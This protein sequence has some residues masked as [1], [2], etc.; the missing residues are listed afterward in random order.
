[1]ALHFWQLGL[2]VVVGGDQ[3]EFISSSFIQHALR[4]QLS[5]RCRI[6]PRQSPCRLWRGEGDTRV[7]DHATRVPF[8]VSGAVKGTLDAE[9]A[10][11]CT[12][13][14]DGDGA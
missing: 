2:Q 12:V 1:M 11:A 10:D 5:T 8:T 7:P 9:M 14:G 13:D 3:F 6:A 4:R